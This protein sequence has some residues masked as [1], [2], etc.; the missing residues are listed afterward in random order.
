MQ[1][2]GNMIRQIRHQNEM[3]YACATCNSTEIQHL[4]DQR[5]PY[6]V[7]K[8]CQTKDTAVS[9]RRGDLKPI[10]NASVIAQKRMEREQNVKRTVCAE[11]YST[12]VKEHGSYDP[13]Y[14]CGNCDGTQTKQM[15]ANEVRMAI[16][17][18]NTQMMTNTFK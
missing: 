5:D 1:L 11:C 15:S 6:T 3:V 14:V 18:Y 2:D 12:N 13:Y 4:G 10:I 16:N 17:L 9:V 8:N 7:C